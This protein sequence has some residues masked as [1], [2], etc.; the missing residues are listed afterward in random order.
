MKMDVSKD[1]RILN[2]FDSLEMNYILKKGEESVAQRH[3]MF[4]VE[5]T[6]SFK[7]YSD[8]VFCYGCGAGYS[9][10]P[11][12]TDFIEDFSIPIPTKFRN[13]ARSIRKQVIENETYLE[14]FLLDLNI[15]YSLQGAR[16][17]VYQS[18]IR[19]WRGGKLLAHDKKIYMDLYSDDRFNNQ[20]I[21]IPLSESE[22]SEMIPFDDR[23]SF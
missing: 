16:E 15:G 20:T 12:L 3:C 18:F 19:F 2:L 22:I 13:S 10:N 17:L 11:N 14:N 8:F 6:P 21:L 1:E 5:K 7:I 4:H 23:D 9:L